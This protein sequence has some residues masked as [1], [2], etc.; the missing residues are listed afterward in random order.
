M[1]RWRAAAYSISAAA[2]SRNSAAEAG[3]LSRAL[4][5][6]PSP[7]SLHL[8]TLARNFA[9]SAAAAT[10]TSPGPGAS[11]PPAGPRPEVP[12]LSHLAHTTWVLCLHLVISTVR[13][14]GRAG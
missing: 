5:K 11:S 2:A 14:L 13:G 10:A 7:P 6:A 8:Q 3:A 9:K 1:S 12:P 4:A